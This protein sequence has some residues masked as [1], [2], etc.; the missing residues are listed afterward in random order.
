MA[1]NE[2]PNFFPPEALESMSSA[3]EEAW[4]ELADDGSI[5][6]EQARRR[7]ART[8][9]ALASVGETNPAKMKQFALSAWRYTPH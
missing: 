2:M 4:L 3:F 6:A 8:I 5:D 1:L 9:V 7:L